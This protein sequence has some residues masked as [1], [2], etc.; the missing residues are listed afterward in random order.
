MKYS[1]ALHFWQSM[2]IIGD[3]HDGDDDHDTHHASDYAPL[4]CGRD[5][6]EHEGWGGGRYLP[7]NLQMQNFH[8]GFMFLCTV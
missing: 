8:K 1:E 3:D 6:P 4:L 5:E 7:I 2:I